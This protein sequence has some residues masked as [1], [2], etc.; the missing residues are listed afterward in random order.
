VVPKFL[1][2]VGFVTHRGGI[3]I[4]YNDPKNWQVQYLWPS[5]Q[6]SGILFISI[7]LKSEAKPKKAESEQE[8]F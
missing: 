7:F 3:G 8:L 6:R 1:Q 2:N 5:E 4:L